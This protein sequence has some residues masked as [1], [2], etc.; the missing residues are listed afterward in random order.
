VLGL[1]TGAAIAMIKSRK[2]REI[3]GTTNASVLNK[4][5]QTTN[6]VGL[7]MTESQAAEKF[8]NEYILMR[9]DNNDPDCETGIVLKVGKRKDVF[10]TLDGLENK[11]NS[12]LFEGI[13]LRNNLGGI[14]F[15]V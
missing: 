1:V 13:N 8:P 15:N 6:F 11:H 14:V 4:T 5:P 2:G 9:M 3:V 10:N 12:F 7:R